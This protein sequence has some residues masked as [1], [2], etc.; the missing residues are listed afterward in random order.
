MFHRTLHLTFLPSRTRITEMRGE[1]IV[2][3]H[4]AQGIGMFALLSK[5]LLDG[6]PHVIVGHYLRRAPQSTEAVAVCFHQGQRVLAGEQVCPPQVAMVHREHG[7]VQLRLDTGNPKSTGLL[8]C[9][10][11]KS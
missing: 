7:H 9:H 5:E 4:A 6:H 3:F 1:T 2:E 10:T 11:S 8:S